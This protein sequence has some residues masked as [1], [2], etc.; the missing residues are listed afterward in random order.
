[1]R[2][3]ETW[4]YVYSFINVCMYCIYVFSICC[5]QHN[6]IIK[7]YH[8]FQIS[9]SSCQSVLAGYAAMRTGTLCWSFC[10]KVFFLWISGA[11]SGHNYLI[12][13]FLS[14]CLKYWFICLE[15]SH[16]QEEERS[17]TECHEVLGTILQKI[18][19]GNLI[20]QTSLIHEKPLITDQ[21]FYIIFLPSQTCW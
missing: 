2:R 20:R 17:V 7:R 10:L 21:V 18:A 5:F 3:T 12:K 9:P 8:Q 14:L 16:F 11:P 13:D 19:S 15:C 6:C 1:M 4:I